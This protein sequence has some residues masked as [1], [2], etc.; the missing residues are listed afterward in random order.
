MYTYSNFG[1]LLSS[2]SY[3][4]LKEC[5]S[6]ITALIDVGNGLE[7][8]VASCIVDRLHVCVIIVYIRNLYFIYTVHYFQE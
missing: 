3:T 1:K 6:K 2:L 7:P 4:K 8:R 5:S